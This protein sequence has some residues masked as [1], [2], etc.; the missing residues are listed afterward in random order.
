MKPSSIFIT[1]VCSIIVAFLMWSSYVYIITPTEKIQ[2]FSILKQI[3]VVVGFGV[4]I[5]VLAVILLVFIFCRIPHLL[6]KAD[7]EWQ[8]TQDNLK[9]LNN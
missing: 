1:S 3:S 5:L 6:E 9:N 8:K 4:S 7:E 2:E